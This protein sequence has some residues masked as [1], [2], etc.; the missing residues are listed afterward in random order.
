MIC[1]AAKLARAL[2]ASWSPVGVVP[3]P[4]SAEHRDTCDRLGAFSSDPDTWSIDRRRHL[5]RDLEQ[6]L[7]ARRTPAL[8]V[9]LAASKPLGVPTR[10]VA[11]T[12][13]EPAS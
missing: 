7:R 10:R 3:F 9:G 13:V 1:D 5:R 8:A 12:S 6:R 4:D 2:V 11:D